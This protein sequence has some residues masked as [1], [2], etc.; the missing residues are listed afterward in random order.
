MAAVDRERLE[1]EVLGGAGQCGNLSCG[2]KK[3]E[4]EEIKQD[5]EGLAE[6]REKVFS[7]NTAELTDSCEK[8]IYVNS[9]EAENFSREIGVFYFIDLWVFFFFYFFFFL[10]FWLPFSM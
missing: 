1:G 2:L 6:N 9:F 5:P 3:Q 7:K 10:L 4:E 8:N